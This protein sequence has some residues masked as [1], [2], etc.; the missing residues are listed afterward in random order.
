MVQFHYGLWVTISLAYLN[1]FKV[2]LDHTKFGLNNNTLGN[3]VW[4]D[5]R[6]FFDH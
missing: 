5:F 2:G 1:K 4:V 3:S 6:L